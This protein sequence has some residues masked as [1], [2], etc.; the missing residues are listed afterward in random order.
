MQDFL[1]APRDP[2]SGPRRWLKLPT[3]EAE[4]RETRERRAFLPRETVLEV[5]D[6]S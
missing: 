4:A 5:L 6:L 3:G 1:E 2:F